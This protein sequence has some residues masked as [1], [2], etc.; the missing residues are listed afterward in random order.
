MLKSNY[1]HTV[2]SPFKI[3]G[4]GVHSGAAVTL[5]VKPALPSTGIRFIRTDVQDRPN[6]VPAHW[7]FV[8]ETRLCTMLSNN[9]GVSVSTVEHLLSAFYG[10]GLDNAVVEIDGAEVPIMDGSSLCFMEALDK[11][12]II[13]QNTNRRMIR[14]KKTISCKEN[15]KEIHLSPA[16]GQ[17]FGF[18]ID[19]KNPLIGFQ[20]HIHNM[21]ETAYRRDIAPA[22]TFGFLHE[23]EQL[24]KA[25]LARGGSLDNVIVIDGD[26]ILNPEGLRSKNEFVHHKILDATGDFFLTGMRLMGRYYGIK[27]GHDM[28]NKIL[29]TLFSRP[30]AFEIINLGQKISQHGII[31]GKAYASDSDLPI[32]ATA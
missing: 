16:N 13:A 2:K 23:V 14:I 18:E 1:Q 8:S 30:D 11:A 10:L 22:R 20:K 17:Y 5:T 7:K 6:V 31:A 3:K 9:H 12:G 27:T 32:V 28:N 21:T 29:H 25:G 19:F 15:D 4:V 24:K 26:K